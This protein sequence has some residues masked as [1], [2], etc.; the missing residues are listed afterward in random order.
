MALLDMPIDRGQTNSQF[1]CNLSLCQSVVCKFGNLFRQPVFDICNRP[2]GRV[3]PSFH[4]GLERFENVSVKSPRLLE[5]YLET[6]SF[7]RGV[8]AR[9]LK[10]NYSVQ[11][12]FAS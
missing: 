7:G 9:M 2:Q 5:V 11:H 3:V 12:V 6:G 8:V 4:F 1:P 10:A